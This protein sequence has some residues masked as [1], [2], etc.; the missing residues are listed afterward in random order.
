MFSLQEVG[1]PMYASEQQ[2]QVQKSSY[3]R[4]TIYLRRRS[5][6][7]TNDPGHL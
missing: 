1:V 3:D 4:E 6:L 5:T 2:I 7:V